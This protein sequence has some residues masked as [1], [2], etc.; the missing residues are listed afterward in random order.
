MHICLTST[1]NVLLFTQRQA[2]TKTRVV[3]DELL[4]ARVKERIEFF[5][6]FLVCN[7]DLL[8]F[9]TVCERQKKLTKCSL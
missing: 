2:W 8:Y 3:F 6:F 7:F 5:S 1:K 9:R 4:S